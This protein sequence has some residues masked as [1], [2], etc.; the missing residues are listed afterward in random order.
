MSKK[1]V[2][3]KNADEVHSMIER[4]AKEKA[5]HEVRKIS[6][7]AIGQVVRQGDIYI[8]AV[9]PRH[10]RG[11]KT[12]NRQLAMG[13][14]RGS[15]HVAEGPVEIYE[16]TTLPEWCRRGTFLGPVVV[17]AAPFTITHPEHAYVE[18]P[19]GVYQVTHQM[20]ART[21]DRVLD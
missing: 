16:G 9:G 21:A 12:E 2:I 15:R 13:N 3:S 4:E 7:I 5:V 20:D 6:A 8:H 19:A 18:L 17:A 10:A 1:L 14:S 11:K